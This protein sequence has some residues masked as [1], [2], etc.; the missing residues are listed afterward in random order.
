MA[1]FSLTVGADTVVGNAADDTVYA[2]AATLNAGDSPTGGAGADVLV[3]VGSSDFR[4]DQLASFTGFES[5]GL[6]NTTNNYSFLTLA[7][8]VGN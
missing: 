4:I 5:I 6:N 2:T 8:A 7:A 3:L 1:N